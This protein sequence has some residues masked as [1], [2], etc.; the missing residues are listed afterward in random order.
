M[1]NFK[2]DFFYMRLLGT[3]MFKFR[4]TVMSLAAVFSC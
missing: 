1:F 2:E 3:V 4:L